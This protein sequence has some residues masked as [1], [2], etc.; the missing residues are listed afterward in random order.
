MSAAEI[1]EELPNL[2][3]AEL[4]RIRERILELEDEYEVEETPALLAA[5]DEGLRSLENEP[6]YTPD[7]VRERISQW[8][9]KSS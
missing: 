8:A 2:P 4:Q 6:I 7:A 1:L 3:P 5:I 9:S